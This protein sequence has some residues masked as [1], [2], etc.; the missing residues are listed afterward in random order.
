M[1][2]VEDRWHSF[3][4]ICRSINI[5]RLIRMPSC[6]SIAVYTIGASASARSS[7]PG[8]PFNVYKCKSEMRIETKLLYALRVLFTLLETRIFSIRYLRLVLAPHA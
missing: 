7:L 6:R 1:K 8:Q 4:R 5:D 2:E 3:V